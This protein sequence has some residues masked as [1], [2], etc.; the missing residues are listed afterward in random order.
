MKNDNMKN[1]NIENNNVKIITL[2]DDKTK[3]KTEEMKK[4]KSFQHGK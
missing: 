4:L 2:K 3:M 1:D